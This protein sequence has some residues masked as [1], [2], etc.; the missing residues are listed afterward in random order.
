MLV[1][2]EFSIEELIWD[3]VIRYVGEVACPSQL[4]LAHGGGDAREVCLFK[5]LRARDFVLP[6]DVEKIVEE[7]EVEMVQLFF[8]SSVRG[9][10]F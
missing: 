1:V 3:A 7:S 6:G 9:P 10:G 2:T 4:I 5:D 8:M